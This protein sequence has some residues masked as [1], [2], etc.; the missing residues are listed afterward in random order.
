MPR[1]WQIASNCTFSAVSLLLSR[2]LGTTLNANAN[3]NLSRWD[4]PLHRLLC[5]PSK[6]AAARIMQTK[7]QMATRWSSNLEPRFRS[8]ESNKASRLLCSSNNRMDLKIHRHHIECP[9]RFIIV[10]APQVTLIDCALAHSIASLNSLGIIASR[11][12]WFI[13]YPLLFVSF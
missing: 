5:P 2:S 8:R 7:W 11:D 13:G 10:W 3:A 12:L 6:E 4:A 9:L 1:D